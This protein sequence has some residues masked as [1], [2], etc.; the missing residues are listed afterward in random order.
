MLDDSADVK[1]EVV[2]QALIY[3]NPFRQ[4]SVFGGVLGYQLSKPMDIV[5]HIY[6]MLGHL[7]AKQTFNEG[8][9]GGNV[10]YNKLKINNELLE[11]TPLSAGIYFFLIMHNNKLLSKGKLAV[12]P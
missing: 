4:N 11:G 2:G 10:G 3:P 8:S 5:V 9:N 6:D 1:P 12:K 7:I